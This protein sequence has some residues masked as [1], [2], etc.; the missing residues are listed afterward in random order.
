MLCRRRARTTA[1]EAALWYAQEWGWAVTLG[2]YWDRGACSC[3][4]ADCPAPGEHPLSVDWANRA[5][6]DPDTIARWLRENPRASLLLPTG[7]TFD[8]IDVPAE[9]GHA[10]LHRMTQLGLTPGPAVATSSG[11]LLFFVAP[12]G[13]EALPDLL[14]AYGCPVG[15]LGICSHG[16]GGHVIAPPSGHG[17]KGT[18]RWAYIS[19]EHPLPLPQAEQI[20]GSLVYALRATIP[21]QRHPARA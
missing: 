13:H 16:P 17:E 12:G 5:S 21:A 9:P 7:Q 4:S 20:V 14:A 8:V 18:A 2:A 3:G 11:R 19:H 15:A 1:L 6:R 10:A